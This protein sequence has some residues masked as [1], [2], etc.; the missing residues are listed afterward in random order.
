MNWSVRSVAPVTSAAARSQLGA[1]QSISDLL[2]N[3][4]NL[5]SASRTLAQAKKPPAGVPPS[6]NKVL[7]DWKS[8][9]D[10]PKAKA[11]IANVNAIVKRAVAADLNTFNQKAFMSEINAARK[12]FGS[13]ISTS[14]QKREFTGAVREAQLVVQTK[15]AAATAANKEIIPDELPDEKRAPKLLRD[16]GKGV[17]TGTTQAQ[18]S[19]PGTLIDKTRHERTANSLDTNSNF[20]RVPGTGAANQQAVYQPKGDTGT[21]VMPINLNKVSLVPFAILSPGSKAPTAQQPNPQFQS[22]S[23]RGWADAAAKGALPG[24][25][26]DEFIGAFNSSFF[27]TDGSKSS[28][29]YGTVVKGKATAGKVEEGANKAVVWDNK[30]QTVKV[31]PWTANSSGGFYV[32]DFKLASL[33]AVQNQFGKDVIGNPNANGLVGVDPLSAHYRGDDPKVDLRNVAT[34]GT[35]IGVSGQGKGKMAVLV[36]SSLSPRQAVAQLR[37]A[38]YAN[39]VA[40]DSGPSS[41]LSLKTTRVSGGVGRDSMEQKVRSERDRETPMPIGIVA[42]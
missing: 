34:A 8:I 32:G 37:S 10:E 25:P 16:I 36:T 35:Y 11:L 28:M 27:N 1:G 17:R 24:L 20:D 7:P 31:I 21:F 4:P 39:V 38:G 29:S 9:N 15:G 30:A 6:I 41:Q 40:L 5:D 19:A 14:A 2:V 13:L 42:K 12:S 23:I 26:K 3:A 18:E 33:K 22:R